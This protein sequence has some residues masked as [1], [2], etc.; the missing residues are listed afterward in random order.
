MPT[1]CSVTRSQSNFCECRARLTPSIAASPNREGAHPNARPLPY[2]TPPGKSQF[3]CV[4]HTRGIWVHIHGDCR[5]AAS[6]GLSEHLHGPEKR[7]HQPFAFFAELRQWQMPQKGDIAASV[8]LGISRGSILR[9]H[10]TGTAQS[11]SG[12]LVQSPIRHASMVEGIRRRE[13]LAVGYC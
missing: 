3:F 1:H 13:Q 12:R 9:F 4:T 6:S 11:A 8:L 5:Q 2:P 10:H 7:R